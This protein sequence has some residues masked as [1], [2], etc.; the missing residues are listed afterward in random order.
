MSYAP[1]SAKAFKDPY[2]SDYVPHSRSPSRRS[3][4]SGKSPRKLG[5]RSKPKRGDEDYLSDFMPF[6]ARSPRRRGSGGGDG[7]VPH[8]AGFISN[9]S[10]S[11]RAR[12][13]S[14]GKS[15][16]KRSREHH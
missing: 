8:E 4:K 15:S 6:D 2:G 13:R 9:H 1:L 10:A 7:F 5:K 16:S 12:H 14:R 11:H 3:R